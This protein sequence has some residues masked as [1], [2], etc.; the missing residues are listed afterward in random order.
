MK[1]YTILIAAL[2]LMIAVFD[3]CKGH[4]PMSSGNRHYSGKR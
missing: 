3:S 2:L 4:P 1:R